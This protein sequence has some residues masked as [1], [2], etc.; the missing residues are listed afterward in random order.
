[1]TAKVREWLPWGVLNHD[2]VQETIEQVIAQWD[3]QWFTTPYVEVA[4]AESATTDARPEGD[5]AGWRVY[6]TM[7][8]VRAGRAALS[9]MVS[10][11]LDMR[12]DATGP[13]E[14]DRYVLEGLEERILE[15]LAEALEARFGIGG[16]A[17]PEPERLADPFHGDGGLIVPLVDPSGRDLLTLAIPGEAVFRHI[18]ASFGRAT[19]KTPVLRPLA[20]ALAG[21]SIPLEAQVGRVELT[22]AELN[23]LAVGDVLVLDRRLEQAVDIAGARSHDVFGKAVLTH[24][25]D[26]FALVF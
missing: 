1:V 13:T 17:R 4:G 8:A 15:S 2:A 16:Q 7:I 18:K 21:V 14:A 20:E 25:E 19:G 12:A 9:R 11:A 3:A 6:R 24:V 26:G 5:G 23:E 22:L 10:R